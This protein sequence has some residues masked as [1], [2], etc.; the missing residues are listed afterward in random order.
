[1]FAIIEMQ[2]IEVEEIAKGP[3]VFADVLDFKCLQEIVVNRRSD[4]HFSAVS[5]LIALSVFNTVKTVVN[6]VGNL[7]F[8][9]QFRSFTRKF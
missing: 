1:M 9:G 5:L 8:A 2:M 7:H 4:K 6:T 3:F